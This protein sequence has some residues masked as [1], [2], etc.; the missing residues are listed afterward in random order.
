MEVQEVV[1]Y[2]G[3]SGQDLFQKGYIL[4]VIVRNHI[5]CCKWAFGI[6]RRHG[7]C[8]GPEVQQLNMDFVQTGAS[9]V[10][11]QSFLHAATCTMRSLQCH[12][13]SLCFTSEVVA[14]DQRFN[15]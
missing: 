4:Q 2:R 11:S 3:M 10:S 15:P 5:R 7:D 12:V 1:C 9:M 6:L 14:V 13:F 8:V